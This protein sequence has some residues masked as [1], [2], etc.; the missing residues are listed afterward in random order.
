MSVSPS[1][2]LRD[3]S[4]VTDT[5]ETFR[6]NI[7]QKHITSDCRALKCTP[8]PDVQWEMCCCLIRGQMFVNGTWPTVKI[9]TSNADLKV[10]ATQI[11]PCSQ[12]SLFP[13][14]WCCSHVMECTKIRR[15]WTMYPLCTSSLVTLGGVTPCS[16][17]DLVWGSTD[18]SV[19]PRGETML[20]SEHLG[21]VCL[22]QQDAGSKVAPKGVC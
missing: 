8:C 7:L 16:P 18:V 20:Y 11:S 14:E 1:Q 3:C 9:F 12:V 15:G 17:A 5:S 4:G 19:R 6:N 13:S 2:Y 22:C 10:T 21:S